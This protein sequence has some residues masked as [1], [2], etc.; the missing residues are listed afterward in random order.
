MQYSEFYRMGQNLVSLNDALSGLAPQ[1]PEKN[2]IHERASCGNLL[3]SHQGT[4][5]FDAFSD[6]SNR[7][8]NNFELTNDG[9]AAHPIYNKLLDSG[10][11]DMGLNRMT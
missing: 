3:I 5:C 8:A 4:L 11:L 9:Y 7:L 10:I 1:K 6:F 2:H